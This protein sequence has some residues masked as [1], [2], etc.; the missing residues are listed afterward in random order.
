[1]PLATPPQV[2]HGQIS[3]PPTLTTFTVPATVFLQRLSASETSSA[4]LNPPEPPPA[5]TPT[6]QN[7][8]SKHADLVPQAVAVGAFIFADRVPE[9]NSSCI[10]SVNAIATTKPR[11]L[12]VRRVFKANAIKPSPL[13]GKWEVPGGGVDDSDA[14]ILEAVAREVKEETG[15]SVTRVLGLVGRAEGGAL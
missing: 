3:Y 4:P 10:V 8:H 7:P 9:P 11:L 14:S 5:T 2:I 12:I 15:L 6:S 1:M 13:D